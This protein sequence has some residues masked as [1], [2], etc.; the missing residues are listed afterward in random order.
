MRVP[1]GVTGNPALAM[2]VGASFS[3]GAISPIA[4]TPSA[5][6][7]EDA[8]GVAAKAGWLLNRLA[9]VAAELHF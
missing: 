4:G 8:L 7:M 5:K 3:P 6:F 2:N 9:L 1:R